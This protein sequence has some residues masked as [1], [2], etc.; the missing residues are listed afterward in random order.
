MT[1]PLIVAGADSLL[2]NH[3]EKKMKDAEDT[4][5]IVVRR[6]KENLAHFEK[7]DREVTRS[8]KALGILELEIVRHLEDFPNVYEK[9]ENKPTCRYNREELKSMSADIEALLS[10]IGD[11]TIF[12]NMLDLGDE[13]LVTFEGGSGIAL[14]SAAIR[15]T[16]LL[17]GVGSLVG[18][19][20][21]SFAGSS[22]SN[23]ADEAYSQIEQLEVEIDHI[24]S[25]MD[26]INETVEQYR[27]T[28]VKVNN[29]YAFSLKRLEHIVNTQGKTDY[30][31]YNVDE[32]HLLLNIDSLAYLLHAMCKVQVIKKSEN[33]NDLSAINHRD[34][35]SIMLC[36][37]HILEAN[38]LE[39]YT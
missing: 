5:E 31:T 16:K 37:K 21:S 23:K 15:G 25:H 30:Y 39:A 32:R 8:I 17:G 18:G 36:A 12:S 19:A 27:K 24:C 9:I 28:L 6:Y 35:E 7:Q 10:R 38:H 1:V 26:E 2:R 11:A 3:G 13:S 4:M 22:L 33:K 34:M 29:A 14:F 20:C